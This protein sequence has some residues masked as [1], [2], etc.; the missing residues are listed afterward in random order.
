MCV[1]VRACVRAYVC[2]CVLL[3]KNSAVSN[4]LGDDIFAITMLNFR[5]FIHSLIAIIEALLRATPKSVEILSTAGSTNAGTNCTTNPQQI[6]HY[7]RSNTSSNSHDAHNH[8][9]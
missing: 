5:R 3:C 6:V 2:V 7:D 4:S 1:C 8:D 9:A